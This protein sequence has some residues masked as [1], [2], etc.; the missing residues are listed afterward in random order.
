M[1]NRASPPRRRATPEAYPCH[2]VRGQWQNPGPRF[3]AKKRFCRDSFLC[4]KIFWI[5]FVNNF[6][7]I[8]RKNIKKLL[9]RPKKNT[10]FATVS[11]NTAKQTQPQTQGKMPEWSI[12]AVSKTVVPLWGTQGSNPCLSAESQSED[13]WLAFFRALLFWTHLVIR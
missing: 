3:R 10:N 4:L 1:L 11:R 5:I 13:F 8:F 12:G 2:F 7:K 9:H 6:R